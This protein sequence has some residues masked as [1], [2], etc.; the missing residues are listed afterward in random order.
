MPTS[1]N[2]TT[3]SY[4]FFLGTALIVSPYFIGRV[5]SFFRDLIDKM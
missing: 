1:V 5:F 2:M 3:L 4:G